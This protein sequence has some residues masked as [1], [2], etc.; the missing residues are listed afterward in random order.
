M[1]LWALPTTRSRIPCHARR[2]DILSRVPCLHWYYPGTAYRYLALSIRTSRYMYCTDLCG[3]NTEYNL[4]VL[5]QMKAQSSSSASRTYAGA[6]GKV[7]VMALL[8]RELRMVTASTQVHSARAAGHPTTQ[9]AA[10][11]LNCTRVRSH[12]PLEQQT[13]SPARHVISQRV[14]ARYYRRP[15][16]TR[17]RNRCS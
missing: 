3:Q 14:C 1:G 16:L 17:P 15:N 2:L 6:R 12:R 5:V 10:C 9:L 7:C 8:A 4:L 11:L 13:T